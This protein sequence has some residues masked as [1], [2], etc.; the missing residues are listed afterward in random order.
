MNVEDYRGALSLRE[1]FLLMKDLDLFVG[2]VGFL[3][4]VAAAVFCPSVIIYG[5]FEAPW[6]SGY[7]ENDNIFSEISCSPCATFWAREVMDLDAL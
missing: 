4:H 7:A 6:Q 2:Q 5:G 1:V 3:M